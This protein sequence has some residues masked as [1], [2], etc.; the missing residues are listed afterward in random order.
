MKCESCGQEIKE[1]RSKRSHDHYFAIIAEAWKNL[2]ERIS[3][4]F[5]SAEHLRSYA[6]IKAGFYNEESV[7]VA[8]HYEALRVAAFVRKFSALAV[9]TVHKNMV[10]VHTPKSQSLKAMSRQDFQMSKDAVLGIIADMIG[11]SPEQLASNAGQA[12]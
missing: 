10:T 9:I 4:Q 7:H 5:P 6:L 2:P 1:A 12:A 8:S 11:V 3:Q